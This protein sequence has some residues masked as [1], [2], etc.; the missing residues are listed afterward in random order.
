[1]TPE[2]FAKA[3]QE[4]YDREKYDSDTEGA[5]WDADKLMC[6]LL[7]KLGY[8]EGVEIYR[9]MPKWYA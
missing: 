7:E 2:E 1:M 4:I 5:H 9:N 3:M 6:D 8:T